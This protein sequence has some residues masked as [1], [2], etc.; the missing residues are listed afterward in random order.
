[1]NKK[2]K[3]LSA[4]ILAGAMSA[5][6][7][8]GCTTGTPSGEASS[9]GTASTGSTAGGAS[10]PAGG[11]K[12]TIKMLVPETDNPFIKTKDRDTYP[13]WQEANKLFEAQGITLDFELVATDQ[14]Q[15]VIQTRMA[16]ANDLPDYTNISKLDET[17][18][19]NLANNGTLLPI[20]KIVP[21]D[22]NVMTFITK[23]VPFAAKAS[24]APD[25]NIYWLTNTLVSE[26]EGELASTCQMVAIRMDWLEK[27][28]LK[29]PT[30]AEEFVTV[31]KAFRDNDVNGNGA[32]D[33]VAGINGAQFLSG[34]AQ[35]FGL[36]TK[37]Y[38]V[39]MENKKIVSPWYQEGAKDYFTYMNRL[40]K[41][42]ILDTTII[43]ATTDDAM[44]QKMAENKIGAVCTYAMQQWLE[45]SIKGAENPQFLPIGP[46]PAKDGIT[47][48]NAVEPAEMAW[49][50]Y[51]VT[52]ACTDTEGMSKF[53]EVVYSEEFRLFTQYGLEGKTYDMVD[54]KPK[55]KNEVVNNARWEEASK[56]KIFPAGYV[57]GNVFPG[58]RFKDMAD[59]LST[60]Q[61]QKVKY[62]I[63]V[64]DY[65]PTHPD[66]PDVYLALPTLDQLARKAEIFTDLD[67]YSKELAANLILGNESI[68]DWDKHMAELKA[69]GLD[70]YLSIAQDQYDR[71]MAG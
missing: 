8:S 40:V 21:A 30:N 27:L 46:L 3:R 69:L 58:S 71:Y 15:V 14:F 62:Q 47:P 60:G 23:T 35:W 36:G 33:E 55:L 16:S 53:L 50:R 44:N 39:D 64:I 2:I 6:V 52:K 41:E 18:S 49:L 7:L 20:N 5:A 70:E 13:A 4:L 1:M 17:T 63:E 54:G 10:S 67:T 29:A 66:N 57:V 25:G 56:D 11:G 22:G 48:I 68:A 28:N 45:P 59:E 65:K 19:L 42:Q 34:I 38:S 9:G 24:T 32:A 51:A 43:G 37:L 31:M 12:H 61:P 26:Y